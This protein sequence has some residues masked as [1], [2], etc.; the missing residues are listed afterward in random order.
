MPALSKRS[1]IIGAFLFFLKRG[2][3]MEMQGVSANGLAIPALG[4]GTWNIGDKPSTAAEESKALRRGLELGLKLIDTA[5]MYGGGRSESLIG[6]AL[7]GVSRNEYLLVSK[8]YPFNAGKAKIFKSCEASLKRLRT[9]YL[10]LYLLHWRGAVPLEETIYCM[11]RLV[12]EGKIR[13]WGVSNFDAADMEELWAMPGGGNCAADQVLYNVGSRGVEFDLLP[14][15]RAHDVAMMAYCPL[16]QGGMLQRVNKDYIHD[17]TLL[18]IAE[19]HGVSV[20]QA[21]LAFVLRLEGVCAIPKAASAVHTEQ[22]AQ[23]LSISL[24]KADL[25]KIDAV[26]WPPSHKMHL[27]IE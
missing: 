25:E 14:W 2:E 8:V 27:D 12:Q 20:M 4:Q 7:S 21:M 17:K 9:D 24:D 19:K 3:Q 5:E 10:D 16:A 1:D 13:R 6:E 22:N 18:E 11:E 15:L 26:F 23:A